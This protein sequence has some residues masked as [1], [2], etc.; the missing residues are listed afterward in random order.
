MALAVMGQVA[1][2]AQNTVTIPTTG[3]LPGVTLINDLNAAFQSLS[4]VFS[5]TTAPTASGLGLS[6]TAGLP[7]HD[8]TTN[9]LKIRDQA[10]ANW[11]LLFQIDETSKQATVN[12]PILSSNASQ[13]IGLSNHYGTYYLTGSATYSLATTT[14]L[15]GGFSFDLV[16]QSGAATISVAGTD[17]VTVNG[18]TG[19]AG[20][21]FTIPVGYMAS[22]V[23]NA[24]GNWQVTL[25]AS[26]L[27][28]GTLSSAATTDLGSLGA[29]VIIVSGTT[30][31][32]S[33]GASGQPGQIKIVTFTSALTLAYNATSMILPTGGVNMPLQA[34]DS[35]VAEA[36][37]SGNWR[38]IGY[39]PASGLPWNAGIANGLATL[40]A[41]G[42]VTGSQ[43]PTATTSAL[44]LVKPDGSTVTIS[45]GVITAAAGTGYDSIANI[46][47]NIVALRS[48]GVTGSA[49]RI[50]NGQ[51]D[52]FNTQTAQDTLN[53]VG[54][55]YDNV[56]LWY[57][58]FYSGAGDVN[59]LGYFIFNGNA[60]DSSTYGNVLTNTG[61]VTFSSSGSPGYTGYAYAV[62]S[63][64][65]YFSMGAPASWLV[66]TGNFTVEG[67]VNLTS[68]AS[69]P[70]LFHS[71]YGG[72]YG[73]QIYTD[74][75]G[76][77][78]Y[79]CGGTTITSS[80]AYTTGAW[81]Y[82]TLVRNGG[83]T[84]LYVNGTS[85]GSSSDSCAIGGTGGSVYFGGLSGG[86][87]VT[88]DLQG[89]RF[90]NVVRSV[91]VPTAPLNG[92]V[93][94][95]GVVD[96]NTGALFHFDNTA[97]DASANAISTTFTS[98]AYGTAKFGTYGASF[99]GTSA[100]LSSSATVATYWSGDLT[101][102]GWINP[103]NFSAMRPVFDTRISTSSAN[104]ILLTINTSGYPVVTINNT[105]AITSTIALTAGSYTHV[106]L[107]RAN[108]TFTL[109]VGGAVAGTYSYS[110]TLIDGKFLVGN[111]VGGTTWFYG[112]MD[113]LRFSA[114]ARWTG[115][116]TPP[117]AAYALGTGFA[118]QTKPI[119][120]V[121]N[122]P[123]TGRIVLR[124]LDVLG[125]VVPGTDLLV[126]ITSNGGT[127]WNT[128]TNLAKADPWDSSTNI[129]VGSVPLTGGS[130]SMLCRVRTAN[131]KP[132]RI[133]AEAC[134]WN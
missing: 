33:F 1:L 60:T 108:G 2:A 114:N 47:A 117:T 54:Q 131:S 14:T 83:T 51:V 56:N 32:S 88:G 125:T 113:E 10:D 96:Y 73:I 45:G 40:G 95:D 63:G 78:K 82:L 19:G 64:S 24:S 23:T 126:D 34:G 120:A 69:A 71:N 90:S 55:Q 22:F 104:G 115:A 129:I 132:Q 94:V 59:T 85:A 74:T 44:G 29:P 105:T 109:Y 99:N 27:G 97:T 89:W 86:Y 52:A 102:D 31:I 50:Y 116:F 5:G 43:L 98:G 17:T 68:F 72:S 25:T 75:S 62:F 18:A 110:G 35:I 26:Q 13:S 11:I 6:T 12:E 8:T 91:T 57:S 66:G 112:L 28:T 128:V 101:F 58:N 4:T 106:A 41:A 15:T 38:V 93:V 107:V 103:T 77:F 87:Y 9:T 36:L 122:T 111:D 37:G 130:T 21:G 124:H 76:H 53:S 123:V 46:N 133:R 119:T 134:Y 39:Q 81:N 61:S 127:T 100:K 118:L 30:G 84:T 121:N 80:S 49:T 92:N 42:Q 16:A 7:W 3:P 79:N 67:W 20:T 65:N 48:L 70:V